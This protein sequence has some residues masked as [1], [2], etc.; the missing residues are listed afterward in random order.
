MFYSGI[1]EELIFGILKTNRKGIQNTE[2]SNL[3]KYISTKNVFELRPAK[4]IAPQIFFFNLES[5]AG[6]IPKYPAMSFPE[7]LSFIAS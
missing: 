1:F 7:I 3:A 4:K 6:F 5:V 2:K